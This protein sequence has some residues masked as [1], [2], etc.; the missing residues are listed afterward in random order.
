MPNKVIA[1][2]ESGIVTANF[3]GKCQS[4][5][6]SWLDLFKPCI[7]HQLLDS[8]LNSFHAKN[9]KVLAAV[10]IFSTAHSL[11]FLSSPLIMCPIPVSPYSLCLLP[12]P[13]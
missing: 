1:N 11:S 3:L 6:G 10:V 9:S 7:M 2:F 8:L 12:L 4:S 13:P 5:L